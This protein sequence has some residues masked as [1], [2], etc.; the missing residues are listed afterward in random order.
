M[1]P[2]MGLQRPLHPARARRLL[3]ARKVS[4]AVRKMQEEVEARR[5]AEEAAAR[6]EEERVQGVR[7]WPIL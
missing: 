1:M 3:A 6:I 2:R 7:H 5:A 4:A